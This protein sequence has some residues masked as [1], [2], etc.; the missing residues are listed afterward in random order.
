V[1]TNPPIFDGH[2]DTLTAILYPNRGEERSFMAR[3]TAGHIDLPR[4][5]AG[6][7]AGGFFALWVGSPDDDSMH[8]EDFLTEGGYDVPLPPALD[9]A[10]ALNRTMETLAYALRLAR[11]SAGAVRI[12]HSARDLR[13]AIADGA[14]AMVLHIEGAGMIDADLAVL[15]VLYAAGVRSLGPVWSRPNIFAEGV[16]FRFPS[17]GDTGGGLTEAGVR[18]VERCNE[19]GVL[20]DLSHITEAGFRDV[21]RISQAP[22]VAT[23]SNAHALCPVSRNLTDAQLDAIAASGGIVGLNFANSFLTSSGDPAE[24]ATLAL[25]VAHIDYMVARM[26]IDHVGFGS[27]FD[28]AQVPPD[29]GDAA[30]LPKLLDALRDA[31]YGEDALARLAYRNWLRVLEAT[32]H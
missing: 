28:G 20:V 27:D 19:L 3:A 24:P 16:P 4:A 30:G 21:A 6:G 31:G 29:L 11:D 12:I 25:M 26:G 32:W 18:L 23:H 14:L 7:L 1:A 13:A 17:T 22:L 10:Y 5:R 8:F 2:N 15:D 9:R